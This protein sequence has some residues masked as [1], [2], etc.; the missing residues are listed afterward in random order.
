MHAY[1]RRGSTTLRCTP[2]ERVFYKWS[3]RLRSRKSCT[4]QL[5]P[6]NNNTRRQLTGRKSS[7]SRRP[8]ELASSTVSEQKPVA[9]PHFDVRKVCSRRMAT[10]ENSSTSFSDRIRPC[11]L[12][13]YFILMRVSEGVRE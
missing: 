1:N 3:S 7:S 6:A 9:G 10:K 5:G 2:K 11:P 13:Y 8:R 4:V 12:P